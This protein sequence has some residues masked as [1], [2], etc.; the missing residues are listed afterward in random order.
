[1]MLIARKQTAESNIHAN[2]TSG[3]LSVTDDGSTQTNT[4]A[5]GTVALTLPRISVGM[6]IQFAVTAAHTFQINVNTLD[7]TTV[8]LLGTTATSNGG[9]NGNISSS[10]VGSMV[11]LIAVSSTQWFAKVSGN[12]T[13]A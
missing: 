13:V 5:S 2:T 4:G 10:L 12:W 9:S 6:C 1:M 7:T 11:E 8:I 3:S